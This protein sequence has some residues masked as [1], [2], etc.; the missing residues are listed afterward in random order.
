[1][2]DGQGDTWT[3]TDYNDA[4]WPNG[5]AQLGY[6]DGDETTTISNSTEVGYFRKTIN[7]ADHTLY[8]DLVLEAI[9]DDGM[10]VYIN[11]TEVWRDNMPSGAI[12]YGTWASSTVGGSSESTWISNTISSNLVTGSNTIAVEIHQRSA[13]SSDISFDF[14][15]TGYAAI[16]AA[17][18]RGP[19]LQ[20]GT[21]DQVTIRYRTNTSTETVINYGTDFN[22]LHLQASELTPK[23]DHEIT[24]SG[25][26]SN[27]TYYYE[28]EDLSGSIEAKSINMY[29]KTAPVIGSEQ[30]VRAWILGDPGTANQNQRNVRDQ[31]YSYVATVTQNPG[32]TDFMLFLGDNAY[33][34]GTDTEYQNAFYDIY[35][36]MLKKSVAWS[37]L[38]NHDG[39]S[40]NSSTQSGPYYDMFTFPK[41]AEV[42]GTAS[43]T[44]A[45]YSFDYAN[46]HF[47]V[48]ESYTMSTDTNQ[49]AWCTADIQNTNQDWIVALF[50]HPAYTKG[51]HDSDT[52][53]QLINMRNNFLP[54]L[55]ANGV[56]LVLNGHSHSYERSY[57]ING[58]YGNSGTF[59]MN[60]HA[61]GLNGHLSGK[62]NTADGAY[63]KLPSDTA[64]AVYITAGSS[65]KISGGSLNHNAMYASIN[66]LGSCVMEVESDGGDGQNLTIKFLNDSGNISDYFT[67]HKSGL[68]LSTTDLDNNDVK[69]Y[70]VPSNSLLN[71]ELTNNESIETVQFYNQLGQMVKETKSN[72]INV[73]NLAA[74]IYILNITTNNRQFFKNII[75]K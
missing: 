28:I 22:N 1:S 27:T 55:E 75:I 37:T 60:T 40:A 69:I 18:T 36:E 2:D 38:G 43:G 72:R 53:S 44:E 7:I 32:Q 35:D 12:N 8:N 34:S 50:H 67:I 6:G 54:I 51:S 66:E 24:L 29:V 13:T 46:I 14:R 10:V 17:L 3:E 31:Y 9:R 42:G 58:H 57:F 63:E 41:A 68:T 30:F 52:E 21:S 20:M 70:P 26:S 15:M 5:M 74:G 33:N 4:S 16:P 45:Y 71:I 73:G 59:D 19:Y 48:L 23:I 11:G 65:G 62:S 25:L 49:I 39:Y 47:I 61:V 64:G 56:D